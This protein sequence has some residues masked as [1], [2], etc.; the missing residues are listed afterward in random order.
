M[1]S[2]LISRLLVAPLIVF[3]GIVFAF[4]IMYTSQWCPETL[5]CED[6]GQI[7]RGDSYAEEGQHEQAIQDFGEA[8]RLDP[9]NAGAYH[10]RGVAYARLGQYEQAIQDFDEAIRL[11]PQLGSAYYNRGAVYAGIGEAK[12]AA[13]D[14]ARAKELGIEAP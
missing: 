10:N 1:L 3:V 12:E 13:R 14:F 4:G 9:Q 6:W 8:I 5:G 2:I 11:D 7:I